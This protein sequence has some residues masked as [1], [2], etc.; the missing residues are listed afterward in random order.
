MK[1]RRLLIEANRSGVL[2]LELKWRMSTGMVKLSATLKEDFDRDGFTVARNFF[3]AEEVARIECE[4]ERY[5]R[6]VVPTLPPGRAMY[7]DKRRPETLKQLAH[8]VEHDAHFRDFLHS[9]RTIALAERLLDGPVIGKALEWFNKVPRDSSA[10][11]PH[12]DGYYFMIDPPE[13]LTMWIA[14]DD[15]DEE[16]GCLRYVR[17]SN[18]KGLLPHVRSEVLGF[19]QGIPA[20]GSDHGEEEVAITTRPGDVLVHHCLTVHLAHLN[21]STNRQRRSLGA[22]YYS[23][24]VAQ[25]V[26][27][28]KSYQQQLVE[29]LTKADK[30]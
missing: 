10:T 7:E 6:E 11:P 16:N 30:I 2:V 20:Y 9:G 5:V 14:L 21:R 18:H 28:L 26:N 17:G 25:D 13:A 4:L 22:I 1:S 19:S 8:I 15:V 29:E 24:G 23:A 3:S 27:R 12:Q